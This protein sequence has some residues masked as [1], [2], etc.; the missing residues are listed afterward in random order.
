MIVLVLMVIL[1]LQCKYQGG[2]VQIL[3]SEGGINITEGRVKSNGKFPS[4]QVKSRNSQ[5]Q[6]SWISKLLQNSSDSFY[7]PFSPFDLIGLQ[8]LELL[9]QACAIT[10]CWVGW[11]D[12]L[13]LVSHTHK[14]T[15]IVPQELYLTVCTQKLPLHQGLS[16]RIRLWFLSLCYNG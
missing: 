10:V 14:R 5:H 2:V 3:D 16:L 7:F 13:S 1:S 4:L 6:P 12:K 8:L 9:S 11:E 15:E